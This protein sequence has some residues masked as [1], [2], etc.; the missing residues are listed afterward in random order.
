M[1]WPKSHSRSGDPERVVIEPRPGGRIYERTADGSEHDWGEV[2]A[3]EPP[4]RLAYLWHIYG[5][6][7][8]A[9]DVEITF[10]GEGDGTRVTIVHGGFERLGA[11]G[12]E[13]RGRNRQGWSALLARYEGALG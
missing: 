1:W 5:D 7:A 3:W 13:L 12:E 4:H 8:D 11:K 9:T 10:A 6:R 2:T